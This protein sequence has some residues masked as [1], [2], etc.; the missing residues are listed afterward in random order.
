[1]KRIIRGT[2]LDLSSEGKGII[3]NGKETIFV[4]GLFIGEEADVEILYSRAGVLFG[5]IIKLHKISKD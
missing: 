4:S 5:K 1:M 3:K 2:C